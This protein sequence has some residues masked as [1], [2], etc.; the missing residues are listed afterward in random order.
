MSCAWLEERQSF[1]WSVYGMYGIWRS[2]EDSVVSPT[3]WK[4]ASY[5]PDIEEE[6]KSLREGWNLKRQHEGGREKT[7]ENSRLCS[8]ADCMIAWAAAAS[9]KSI[10]SCAFCYPVQVDCG[11]SLYHT[12]WDVQTRQLPVRR[13]SVCFFSAGGEMLL[14][15]VNPMLFNSFTSCWRSFLILTRAVK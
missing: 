7:G 10:S 6:G 2:W 11:F 1:T 13:I 9:E 15:S 5:G 4:L 3:L 12:F 8:R 14:V